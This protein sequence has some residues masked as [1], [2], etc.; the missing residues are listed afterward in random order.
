MKPHSNTTVSINC[1][2]MEVGGD[3]SWGLPILESY[4]LKS[5]IYKFRFVIRLKRNTK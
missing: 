3:N 4:R 1:A 5:G 2:R